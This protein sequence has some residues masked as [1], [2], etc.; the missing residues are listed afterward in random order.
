[1]RIRTFENRAFLILVV[2]VTLGFMWMVRPFMLPI[3]WAAVLAVLFRPIYYGWCQLFGGWRNTSAALTLIVAVLVLFL[4]M[5]ILTRAVVN[6]VVA[7]YN[8]LVVGAVDPQAPL[9]WIERQLPYVAEYL[10]QYG[11]APE[12]VQAWAVEAA[13]TVSQYVAQ[14]ALAFG[15]DAARF[16]ILFSLM[17]YILFFFI[18]DGRRIQEALIRAL[19]LGDA[20]ERRLFDRFGV[21][22]RATVKG[23]LVVA[24]VQGTLGGLLLWSV[25]IQGAVLWGVAMTVLSI[26]PAV[27]TVL[28]WGPAGIYLLSV[29]QVWQGVF[30]LAGGFFV[31]SIIDNILRPILVG[32]DTQMPDY[33]VL[34]STLGGLVKFGLSGFVLGPMVAAFFLVAWQIF[35]EDFEKLD[36]PGAPPTAEPDPDV[37]GPG[38]V[39]AV[40]R[41]EAEI[42][43]EAKA[44]VEARAEAAEANP[45]GHHAG[46]GGNRGDGPHR[47]QISG[48]V[49]RGDRGAGGHP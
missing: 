47:E 26:I 27:G 8:R 16:T 43:A 17:L 3:F 2:L 39:H 37:P 13:G 35:T 29:G 12:N 31:V 6:E 9:V 22:A 42:Q 24:A 36:A 14:Q 20:R 4:P 34:I 32:R 10:E 19:P 44:E 30:V 48:A 7:L 5:A 49:E 21:V 23:T 25:G 33:L 18:R 41:E 40:A 46:E 38:D 11:I 15:Q 28:V 1:M 45:G